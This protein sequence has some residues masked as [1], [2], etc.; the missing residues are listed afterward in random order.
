M[1][2]ILNRPLSIL[3]M[4]SV[5]HFTRP[6]GM[7]AVA[8]KGVAV[9][10]RLNTL[11]RLAQR[12][13]VERAAHR[14]TDGLLDDA[15]VR[16]HVGLAFR[17]GRAMAAHG[18][19]DEGAHALRLKILDGRA[20]DGG[21]VRDA[22]AAYADGHARSGL[23]TR[24]EAGIVKLP[25]DFGSHIRDAAVGETLTHEEQAGEWHGFMVAKPGRRLVGQ[26]I[27][28]RGLFGRTCS[29]R[30]LMKNLASAVSNLSGGSICFCGAANRGR[31][32]LLRNSPRKF[33]ITIDWREAK[34]M[35]TWLKSA[36]QV[37]LQDGPAPR[38]HFAFRQAAKP[39][40]S[41]L[42]AELP[43]PQGRTDP[44]PEPA[45][46]PPPPP[47][48]HGRGFSTL[49]A[50]PVDAKSRRPGRPAVAVGMP[51]ARHPP[52]RS[53][54]AL[55][56]HTVLTLDVLPRKANVR[57]RMQNFDVRDEAPEF[58]PKFVP[59]PAGSLTPPPKLPPPHA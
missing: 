8:F 54:R 41:R 44:L 37:P 1:A 13:D 6:T 27:V 4:K 22:T 3:P 16:Q 17:G 49:P 30:N 29:P 32:R 24:G 45:H 33:L 39:A 43:A 20:R 7:H 19:K 42:R 34:K 53:V 50:A 40:E 5:C 56:T 15:V 10:V 28:V 52:H 25:L 47:S 21:D 35:P 57:I 9:H 48:S 26:T 14:A 59:G 55:L 23:E 12:H 36:G 18:R 51:V 2:I 58:L 46:Q 38:G 31:G 11:R